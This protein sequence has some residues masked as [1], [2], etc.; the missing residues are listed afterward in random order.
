MQAQGKMKMKMGS[1]GS[2][3]TGS[4]RASRE[5]RRR[6]RRTGRHRIGSERSSAT[7]ALHGGAGAATGKSSAVG[8]DSDDQPGGE[9][10]DED[11]D[12]GEDED[13]DIPLPDWVRPE[14]SPSLLPRLPQPL[15]TSMSTHSTDSSHGSDLDRLPLWKTWRGGRAGASHGRAHATGEDEEKEDEGDDADKDSI[16]IPSPADICLLVAALDEYDLF[17]GKLV[18]DAAWAYLCRNVADCS[19]EDIAYL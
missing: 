9:G 1:D 19:P 5:R 11:E 4:G 2:R 8:D 10:G 15:G 3:S 16:P 13:E 7:D 17:E 12:D 6:S 14:P 18:F